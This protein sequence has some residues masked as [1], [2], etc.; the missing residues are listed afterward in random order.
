VLFLWQDSAGRLR[1]LGQAQGAF[2]LQGDPSSPGDPQCVNSLEGLV[3]LG[4]QAKRREALPLRLR[5]GELRRRV[6]AARERR[7]R[8]EAAEELRATRRREARLREAE[9]IQRLT[10][11][12]PGNRD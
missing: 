11:G 12:K 3:L 10:E 2:R 5:L 6:R 4:A 7:Q 1:V 8:R 9:L